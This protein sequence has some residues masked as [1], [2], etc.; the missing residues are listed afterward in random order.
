VQE[1][2]VARRAWTWAAAVLV[3]LVGASPVF[4]QGHVL[5]DLSHQER[6]FSDPFDYTTPQ[7]WG[8][9]MD[10]LVDAGYTWS[11]IP[12]G[13]SITPEALEG[14]SFLIVAEPL[15]SFTTAEVAAVLDYVNAGG[16][17]LLANDF[18]AP[19]NDLS[20]PTDV[21]FLLGPSS[22]F[23]TVTDIV[24]GHPV[25]EGIDQI[26]WPIGTPLLVGSSAEVLASFQGQP[27]LA[28]QQYG[29]GRIVYIGDNELF[30]NYGINNPENT[31]LLLNIAAWLAGDA[32]GDGVGNGDDLCPGTPAGVP[33]DVKGCSYAQRQAAACPVDG[34]WR[35]HGHYVA[36]V[37]HTAHQGVKDDLIT[38]RQAWEAIQAAARSD[39]GKDGDC[40]RGKHGRCDRHSK[41][42]KGKG[43]KH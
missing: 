8:P 13:G 14:A 1:G 21:L 28:V 26:D 7:G 5:F 3:S 35:N 2:Q 43:G 19:I 41:C 11:A 42:K 17:L 6:V 24:A 25:T 15:T 33:V 38:K 30:A 23:A 12:E 10:A 40:N 29:A 22:G 16:G 32:D 31:P 4:P 36:C 37:V 20:A 9:A 39:V 18:N 27:I 34:D